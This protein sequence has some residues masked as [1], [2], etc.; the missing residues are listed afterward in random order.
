MKINLV[1]FK[2]IIIGI[3][4][5]FASNVFSKHATIEL[6]TINK[7]ISGIQTLIE[8]NAIIYNQSNEV[9]K[10]VKSKH[11]NSIYH[12]SF[13]DFWRLYVDGPIDMNLINRY[14]TVGLGAIGPPDYYEIAPKGIVSLRS[15]LSAYGI[16]NPGKYKIRAE[17][18][19][20][21]AP[22]GYLKEVISSEIYEIEVLEPEGIDRLV[23]D[24][25]FERIKDKTKHSAQKNWCKFQV[26]RGK[27]VHWIL[28]EYP[29]STYA[30]WIITQSIEMLEK[31]E[32]QR[33][34]TLIEKNKFPIWNSVPDA[35]SVDGYQ[36]KSGR[37][38][39]E[40]EIQWAE[41]IIKDHP[42]FPFV[43]RLQLVI[44]VDSIV[45]GDKEKGFKILKDIAKKTAID[46]G[47]WAQ[48]F[49][50]LYE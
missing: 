50:S 30:A 24:E 4:V 14:R 34:K 19:G 47:K 35:N 26:D 27:N 28:H 5:F 45:I 12:S 42:D 1:V 22:E 16:C 40:W 8:L 41:L 9:I 43:R 37:K 7:S 39:A 18:R 33:I 32:P 38:K 23:Y 46:E 29:A 25:F 10:M 3:G 31:W 6:K 20:D 15:P 2:I 36:G 21:I 48:E 11:G 44:A 49:L 17:Y 13:E